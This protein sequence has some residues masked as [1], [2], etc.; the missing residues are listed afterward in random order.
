MSWKVSQRIFVLLLLSVLYSPNV[1]ASLKTATACIIAIVSGTEDFFVQTL[2]A[3]GREGIDTDPPERLRSTARLTGSV[4]KH[5]VPMSLNDIDLAL[6]S[7][8]FVPLPA[9]SPI[10][11]YPTNL[12]G[13]RFRAKVRLA[14]GEYGLVTGEFPKWQR[15]PFISV[16]LKAIDVGDLEGYNRQ[17]VFVTVNEDSF[18]ARDLFIGWLDNGISIQVPANKSLEEFSVVHTQMGQDVTALSCDGKLR[19]FLV[20]FG[21]HTEEI[22]GKVLDNRITPDSW[23]PSGENPPHPMFSYVDQ[24]GRPQD[25]RW[26]YDTTELSKS[27]LIL[28]QDGRTVVVPT[29]HLLAYS[30]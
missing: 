17:R 1:E 28:T 3:I 16:R 6:R 15:K 21:T 8:G 14:S 22:R 13:R 25:S 11:K 2:S 12:G 23:R 29:G 24:S 9:G 4:A 20:N 18:Y 26:H 27:V 10:H 5:A 19:S 30:N 7:D